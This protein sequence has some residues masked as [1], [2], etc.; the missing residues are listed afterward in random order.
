MKARTVGAAL[1]VLAVV[2]VG[3]YLVTLEPRDAD[4]SRISAEEVVHLHGIAR[5]PADGAVYIATH[6]GL[7]RQAGASGFERVADR[8]EDIMGFSIA[9]PDDF[10]ASG[11]P[12]LR[13]AEAPNQRGLIRSTDGGATWE[14][15]SLS[16]E[17]DLHAIVLAHDAIYVA[18]SLSESVLVSDDGGRTWDRRGEVALAALAVDPGDPD[19]LIGADYDGGL[20][21]SDDG[22]RTWSPISGPSTAAVVWHPSLGLVAASV[23]GT[24]STSEDG[25]SWEAVS[26]LGGS[27]PVLG[28]DGDGVLAATDGGTVLRTQDGV[29]WDAADGDD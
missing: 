16:G 25:T 14:S 21:G 24:V 10:L 29:V 23:D 27:G 2:A 9:G 6:A 13:Q 5:N 22:G 15:V 19:R 17:A 3:A 18:D 4:A 7:V 1:G 26:Q 12:D 20:V 8:F 11:H 28:I